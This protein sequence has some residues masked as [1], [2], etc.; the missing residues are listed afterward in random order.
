MGSFAF[1]RLR[2]RKNPA[3]G[4][5]STLDAGACG[6]VVDSIA[7]LC[8]NH[9]LEI[10]MVFRI[11]AFVMLLNCTFM[12]LR[13]LASLDALA[14]G[15][16]SGDVGILFAL[17]CFF[18]VF[19]AI[20]CGRWIDRAGYHKP[21]LVTAACFFAGA[22]VPSLIR[23]AALGL[24]PLYFCAV[25]NGLGSMV[26]AIGSNYLVGAVSTPDT[27]TKFFAWLTM[28][29]S[30]AGLS[31]PVIA[32]HVVDAFGF[33][34]AYW[35]S[36]GFATAGFCV[37]VLTTRLLKSIRLP[38]PRQRPK[39]SLDLLKNPLMLR[40][41]VISGVVSM[42]WDLE[43][44]MFPVYGN[45]VGLSA[46]NIGWLVGVFYAANFVVL[47]A[48]SRLSRIVSDWQC[49]T[50]CLVVTALGYFLF[51]NF[52]T[53]GPLLVIAVVLGF[54]LGMASPSILSILQNHAPV[55]RVAEAFGIRATLTNFMHFALPMPYGTI[56]VAVSAVSLFYVCAGL[57]AATAF[58]TI[59]R[60]GDR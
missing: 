8:S 39:H 45:L 57:I 7:E 13:V 31:A 36:A 55:G 42:A 24:W 48:Q 25:A 11:I 5:G 37:Y 6:V 26:L 14:N 9:F 58:L 15:A 35:V 29:N 32:G 59:R 52:S 23:P 44:F 51:P 1:E 50:F 2:R 40:I 16:S 53:M 38:Q 60:K 20:P 10:E 21:M 17:L 3:A 34:Q 41:L 4:V 47:F 27:R 12:S 46:S 22:V 43:T 54:G 30:A 18:P 19:L 28:G 33:V 49:L 56:L